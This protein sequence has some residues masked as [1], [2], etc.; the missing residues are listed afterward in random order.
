MNK[1]V[2]KQ[3]GHIKLP[4]RRS[5]LFMMVIMFVVLCVLIFILSSVFFRKE[6]YSQFDSKLTG[7]ITYIENNI[8]ADDL[9]TCLETGEHSEKYDETQ[10][11]LNNMIS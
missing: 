7:V 3:S 9:K 11:F 6:L 2:T 5:L 1:N 8:D 10:Q 4:I